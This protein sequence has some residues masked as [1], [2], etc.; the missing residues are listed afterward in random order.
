MLLPPFVIDVHVREKGKRGFR[1][2]LPFF[3]L[4]PLLFAL[5]A[6]ALTVSIV[7]DFFLLVAGAR[8]HH[9][10]ALLLGVGSLLAA[11]RGMNGRIH[12][13]NDALV[14]FDIY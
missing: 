9:Y 13:K 1:M 11:L 4:W 7:V 2:W 12:D 10:T 8:Y 3:L 5:V 14:H 6:L